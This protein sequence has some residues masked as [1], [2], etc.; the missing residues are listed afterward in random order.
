KDLSP[1]RI[2][3]E[4]LDLNDMILT[5]LSNLKNAEDTKLVASSL[6]DGVSKLS[7]RKSRFK[8]K[9]KLDESMYAS[10]FNEKKSIIKNLAQ[11]K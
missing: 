8:L 7:I 1:T 3:S 10:L 11:Y 4:L 6:S 5:L 9:N 2:N